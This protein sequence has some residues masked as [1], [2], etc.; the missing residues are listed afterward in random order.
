M[1]KILSVITFLI[2]IFSSCAIPAQ[3]SQRLDEWRGQPEDSVYLVYGAPTRSQEL[4]DGR[5]IATYDY[6]NISD[7]SKISGQISFAITDGIVEKTS[8]KGNRFALSGKIKGPD[9][10]KM[11]D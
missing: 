10:R 4:T 11:F 2:L 8:V 9:D 6:E 1:K 3:W 7:G 5:K